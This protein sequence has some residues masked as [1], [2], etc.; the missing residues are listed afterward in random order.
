VLFFNRIPN[1]ITQP[2]STMLRADLACLAVFALAVVLGW[3][4]GALH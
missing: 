1:A 2:E 4:I 3:A